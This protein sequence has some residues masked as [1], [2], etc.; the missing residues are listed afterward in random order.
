MPSKDATSWRS[1]ERHLGEAGQV[2]CCILI[3][4]EKLQVCEQPTSASQAAV[5]KGRLKHRLSCYW[6]F[7]NGMLAWPV[8]SQLS[9]TTHNWR[10]VCNCCCCH[11]QKDW[12]CKHQERQQDLSKTTVQ[13]WRSFLTANSDQQSPNVARYSP[14]LASRPHRDRLKLDDITAPQVN[15]YTVHKRKCRE[16]ATEHILQFLC[17]ACC[18]SLPPVDPCFLHTCNCLFELFPNWSTMEFLACCSSLPLRSL[19]SWGNTWLIH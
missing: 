5:R 11:A 6:L 9:A 16:G 1:S 4:S 17:L 15:R 3:C 13:R 14:C 19:L 8:Q 10:S 2:Q 18:S 7:T 12:I